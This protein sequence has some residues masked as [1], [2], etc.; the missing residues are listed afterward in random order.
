MQRLQ[1]GRL[2]AFTFPE[3]HRSPRCVKSKVKKVPLGTNA[4]LLKGH[5]G[6]EFPG[7]CSGNQPDQCP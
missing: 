4:S 6:L 3:M 5:T 7:W 1:E 2:P